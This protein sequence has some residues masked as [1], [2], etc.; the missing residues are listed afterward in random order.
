MAIGVPV[1]ASLRPKV[2]YAA[3]TL[4]V[5]GLGTTPT[6]A[7]LRTAFIYVP[8]GAIPSAWVPNGEGTKFQLNRTHQP[9]EPVKGL[10]QVL[11]G[12]DHQTADAGPN[13]VDGSGPSMPIQL[14]ISAI[15]RP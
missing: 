11:G 5:G 14:K 8:N 12:L 1:L 4:P 7:P 6:G 13:G 2:Q 10:I 3:R 15:G 9:L